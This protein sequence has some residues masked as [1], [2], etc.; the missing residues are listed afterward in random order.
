[1]KQPPYSLHSFPPKGEIGRAP[2]SGKASE[3][4]PK[5]AKSFL[6]LPGE[7]L[8]SSFGTAGRN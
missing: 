2:G 8:E 1:M 4:P 6:G 7:R 3:P 5:G